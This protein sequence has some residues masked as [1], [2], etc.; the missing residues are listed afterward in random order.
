MSITW[1]NFTDKHRLDNRSYHDRIGRPFYGPALR[2]HLA[3]EPQRSLVDR[4]G[5][6]PWRVVLAL[7]A[8]AIVLAAVVVML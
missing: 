5:E 8:A 6:H 3:K 4:Y 2:D 1:V 7:I